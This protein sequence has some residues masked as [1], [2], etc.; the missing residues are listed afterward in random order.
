MSARRLRTAAVL[1]ISLAFLLA[2]AF[3]IL[4]SVLNSLKTDSDVLAYPPKL[5]L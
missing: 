5:I 1:A 3:P 2:W 4:W